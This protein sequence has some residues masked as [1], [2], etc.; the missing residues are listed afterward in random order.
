[1]SDVRDLSDPRLTW[2]GR[3]EVRVLFESV[4]GPQAVAIAWPDKASAALNPETLQSQNR[5]YAENRPIN[6]L[7]VV[8]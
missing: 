3:D 6:A 5:R 8:R 1:M 4:W 7:A 2:R